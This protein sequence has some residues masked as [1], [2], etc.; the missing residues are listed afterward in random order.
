MQ[1]Y[2]VGEA[3]ACGSCAMRLKTEMP[4]ETGRGYTR[5]LLFGIG[6]AIVGMALYAT[7]TIV[8]GWEIGLVS[9][10]VGWLV[11]KGMV[12]GARGFGGRKYQITAAALTYFAVAVSAVPIGLAQMWKNGGVEPAR[13]EVAA[14]KDSGKTADAAKVQPADNAET[15]DLENENVEAAGGDGEKMGLGGALLTLLLVGLASPFLALA[16]PGQGLI[17][18]LILFI[19]IHTAWRLTGATALVVD[20]PFDSSTS[21]AATSGS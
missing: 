16:N 5:G 18:L 3:M 19:G 11:G 2:R 4:V 20:G 9:L 7:V 17:G 6:A 10:A 14:N 13:V 8:T 21:N 15:A 1:Y 12:K